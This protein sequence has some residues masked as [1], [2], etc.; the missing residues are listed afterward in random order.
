MVGDRPAGPGLGD[1]VTALV[2]NLG[3]DP[4]AHARLQALVGARRARITLDD[5]T[6]TVALHDGRLVVLP[7]TAEPVDGNGAATR[8]AV[9]ALL[10]AR[11]DATDALRLGYV[12]ATGGHEAVT[13]ILG[14]IEL[15]LD[16]AT[17]NPAL[18]AVAR[19]YRQAGAAPPPPR[20]PDPDAGARAAAAEHVVLHR[21]GLLDGA[22]GDGGGGGVG[23]GDGAGG[24]GAGGDGGGDGHRGG[25]APAGG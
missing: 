7:G 13:R 4:R 2:A 25:G 12:T 23:A 8:A 18:R 20:A 1:W 11:L 10:D 21:L 15:L 14:A 17:R 16:A 5:E 9:L 3:A 24:D 19:S 6:V 22:G